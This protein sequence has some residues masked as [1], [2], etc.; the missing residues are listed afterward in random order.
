MA[1][2]KVSGLPVSMGET[3]APAP[4]PN[5]APADRVAHSDLSVVK[6]IDKASPKLHET[7]VAPAP[8]D[9]PSVK[10]LIQQDLAAKAPDLNATTSTA[11]KGQA[12]PDMFTTLDGVKGESKD[13][14]HKDQIMNL[15]Y[16]SGPKPL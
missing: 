16:E 2:N 4:Q 11:K 15:S 7:A 9:E 13:D 6:Y 12:N 10:S 5:E 14:N 8:L 1:I 3:I